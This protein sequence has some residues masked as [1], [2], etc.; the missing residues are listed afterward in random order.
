MVRRGLR[1]RGQE[2]LAVSAE[3]AGP[4]FRH[5][6]EAPRSSLLEAVNLELRGASPLGN[7]STSPITSPA[8]QKSVRTGSWQKA[9][10][11]KSSGG[12]FGE[13]VSDS[14][15]VRLLVQTDRAPKIAVSLTFDERFLH[16][17]FMLQH[18][19][20][21]E[22]FLRN[23]RMGEQDMRHSSHRQETHGTRWNKAFGFVS[24]RFEKRIR[25]KKITLM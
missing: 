12:T 2:S 11:D 20:I 9:T 10:E 15:T 7:D 1:A 21:R 14:I 25:G 6:K 19:K 24:E 17:W 16:L 13:K 18:G 22:G 8:P 5:V 23:R 3:P 4:V